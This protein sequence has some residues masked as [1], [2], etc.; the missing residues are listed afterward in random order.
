VNQQTVKNPETPHAETPQLN[1]RDILNDAL[2]TEKYLCGSYATA[3]H[4]A[5]HDALYQIIFTQLR[6]TSKQ[7]RSFYD[8][9]FTHGWYTLTPADPQEIKQVTQQFQ[10]YKQ[11]LQ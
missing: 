4:E 2:S 11:Q 6:D 3:M 5:S 8:L 10:E 1:D 7:Q 9:L